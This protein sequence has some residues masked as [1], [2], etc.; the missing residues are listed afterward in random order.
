M[1]QAHKFHSTVLR[2][3]DIRGIIG[4]TLKAADARAI[5]RS[6]GT[7]V[8][9]GGGNRV[10]VGYD[11]RLSSPEL[12]EALVEGLV[13]TGLHVERIGLGPTPMLY[14]AVRDREA[15]AGVMITGSHNPPDYNG[16]KMM[17]GKGPVYGRMIQE[18]G[19]IA[20][21]GD[22]ATGQG[23]SERIDIRDAYVTRL[24]RDYAGTRDL[25]VAWDA[26][27]GASA[28]ILKRLTAKLPGRHILLFDEIDGNFPNHHPDPT[29]PENLVDLQR[30][31]A[32]NKCD[33]GIAFDGDGDRIGAIDHSG[34][35][36]WGD[37]LVAIYSTEVLKTHPGATIIA[38]VKASQTLFDEIERLGGKPL[39]YKT[40]HSLL[41]AKMAETG[42]PLAGEMSGHIFF[43]D[44]WYGFDDALYC[45]VRLVSLV[46]NSGGTL[47]DLRDKLPEVL[48]TPEIR[49]QVDEER[50]FAVVDEVKARLKAANAKVN[51]IDGVR[52]NT[53]D[54]WWL[55]R[56]SNTQDVLVARAE[57]FSPE[58]LHRLKG[59]LLDQLRQSGIDA[60]SDI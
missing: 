59:L 20:G 14:F 15:A 1:T 6:F 55:L 53:E 46:S 13:S 44:K 21:K 11:G 7:V 3:Y 19:D 57:A 35:I 23:S 34:R 29:V 12:E 47:A 8:V 49:F 48:N 43:A 24:L 16:F 45:G 36:V 22:Y 54:G 10:C 51:D 32:D 52:V 27:N 26:G 31:V 9:R 58:G 30:A 39:M 17:L 37:Q 28:D 40:G 4:K 38:D 41:K 18:L 50:K 33:L 5:G 56:A 42:S 2:E 25:T 60:P